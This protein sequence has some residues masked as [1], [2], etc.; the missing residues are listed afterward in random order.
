MWIIVS[1]LFFTLIFFSIVPLIKLFCFWFGLLGCCVFS[2]MLWNIL[3]SLLLFNDGFVC[4]CLVS[5]IVSLSVDMVFLSFFSIWLI[6]T[7]SCCITCCW[8]FLRC[9]CRF[10]FWFVL[11]I[12]ISCESFLGGWLF[13]RV[14]FMVWFLSFVHLISC[15]NYVGLFAWWVAISYFGCFFLDI[16]AESGTR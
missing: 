5:F 9:I 11:L 6:C 1:V 3:V 7:V 2:H 16:I 10:W 14:S 15:L 13:L 4:C 12:L 8:S